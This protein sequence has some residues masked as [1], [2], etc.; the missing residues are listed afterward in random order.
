VA[1][2]YNINKIFDEINKNLSNKNFISAEYNLKKILEED[3]NNLKALFLLGSIF[4]E[5]KEFDKSKKYLNKVIDIDPN[6]ANANSN[7]GVV[8]INLREFDLAK[9]YILRAIEINPKHLDAYNYLGLIYSELG[10]FEKGLSSTK[11]AL[12]LNENYFQGYNNLG[13][14]YKKFNFFNDAEANFKRT[15]EI[16]SNFTQSYYNL[17]ELYEKANENEK[18][19]NIIRDFEKIFNKNSISTLYES[20]IFYKREAFLEVIQN[21]KPLII[22]NDNKLEL[23]RLNLLAKSYD[24]ID[25]IENAFLYFEK[26]NMLNLKYKNK[27]IDKNNFLNKINIRINSFTKIKND[28]SSLLKAHYD[29]KPVFMIGFPRSGTTLLDTILRSHQ[30]IEVI[31]EKHMMEKLINSLIKLTNNSVKE[32]YH[33]NNQNIKE[34]R[35]NYFRELHLYIKNFDSSKIYIDKLPLNIIY[36][37]EIIRIFPNAKFI[38]SIRHPCDSVLSCYMQNFNLNDSMSNFLNL[39]DAANIYNLVMNLLK[40]YKKNFVFNFKEIKYENIVSNFNYEIKNVLDFLELP[41][42][43]KVIEYQKTAISRE[44]IFTPSYD[45]VI[46][47]LYS[48]SIG[49][50]KKYKNKLSKVYPILKPWIKEFNYE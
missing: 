26:T 50:W 32:I 6:I 13:L 45:Q 49:R 23:D 21:L 42:D 31:E 12:E 30:M 17:M 4:L 44:R 27:E 5:I 3:A 41:W 8:H 25:D 43:D 33:I 20:H 16:N 9:K 36:V 38:I 2:S 35:E 11:K 47:P 24:K 14:I 37:A 28:N 34:L 18:L 29:S 15:I 39:D 19:E 1:S 48:Q 10:Q 40:I 46:K 22:K 7:L